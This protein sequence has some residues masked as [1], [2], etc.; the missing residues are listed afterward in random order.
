MGALEPWHIV[1]VLAIVLIVFGAGKMG[2]A[3]AAFGK[4]VRDFRSAMRDDDQPAAKPSEPQLKV[5]KSNDPNVP[6]KAS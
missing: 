2:D 1:V 4:S 6:P 5:V 3:G